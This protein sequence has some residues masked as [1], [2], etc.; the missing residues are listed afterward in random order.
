MN[1]SSWANTFIELILRR[2]LALYSISRRLDL[3]FCSSMSKRNG[4]SLSKYLDSDRR[5]FFFSRNSMTSAGILPALLSFRATEATELLSSSLRII[6]NLI[7]NSQ[8]LFL[9]LC[10][11]SL[12]S[13]LVAKLS[14]L[15]P[16][17]VPN[18]G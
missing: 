11:T 4:F 2:M 14:L 18:F 16:T 6:L 7:R 17:L 9:Y 8:V 1:F 15:V 5:N 3:S 10:R 12:V 13:L